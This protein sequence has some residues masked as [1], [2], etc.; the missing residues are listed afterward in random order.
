[1]VFAQNPSVALNKD[2]PAKIGMEE[3]QD[4]CQ[5]SGCSFNWGAARSTVFIVD[6]V[7]FAI[8]FV[9]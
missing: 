6:H 4:L 9:L 1:M 8:L 5:R 3:I 7:D 2:F